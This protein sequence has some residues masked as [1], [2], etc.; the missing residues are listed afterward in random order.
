[1][2]AVSTTGGA[3]VGWVNWTWPLAR[4]SA[5]PGRLELHVAF[6]KPYVF[7]GSDVASLQRYGRLPI[8]GSGIR[9]NHVRP[10]YPPKVVF[11]CLGNPQRL[12]ERITAAGFSAQAGPAALAALPTGFPVKW[13][14]VL[15]WIA[16]W[17]ALWL[18]DIATGCA[19]GYFAVASLILTA[20][21]AA[22]ILLSPRIQA[23]VLREGHNAGAIRPF[24]SLLLLIAIALSIGA[25][26]TLQ[27]RCAS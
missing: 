12:I 21:V 22:S 19:P 25:A 20:A 2:F 8:L 18:L 23:L 24:L 6:S 1:M 13:S 7:T 26:A 16:L 5:S 15:V 10:D 9:I 27:S 17:N 4:L 3:Q 11:W 14:V